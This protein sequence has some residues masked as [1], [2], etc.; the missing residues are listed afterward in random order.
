[1]LELTSWRL[2]GPPLF[3]GGPGLGPPTPLRHHGAVGQGG[4]QGAFLVVKAGAA[5]TAQAALASALLLK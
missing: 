5:A 4:G 1:M 2:W 3:D